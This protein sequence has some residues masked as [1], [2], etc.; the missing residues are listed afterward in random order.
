MC[1]LEAGVDEIAHLVAV[2]HAEQATER[3]EC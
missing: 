3:R 2:A 1:L